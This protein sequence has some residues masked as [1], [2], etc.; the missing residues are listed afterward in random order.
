MKA[1]ILFLSLTA[2][3]NPQHKHLNVNEKYMNPQLNAEEWNKGFQEKDRD[4]VVFKKEIVNRLPI[5]EGQIIADVGAGTGQFESLLSKKVGPQG[6]VYAVDIAPAFIPFMKKRFAEEKL[7]NVEVV[8][9][10]L[11]S[12][13]LPDKSVDLIVVIDTYHHFDQHDKML[14]DFKRILKDKGH[15]V[16]V[17]FKRSKNARKWIMEH[18]S[19]TQEEYVNEITSFGFE[20]LRQEKI[21]FKESFQLTFRKI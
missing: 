9:S 21:P 16:V 20:F 2:F 6:K 10:K 11:D 13:T 12:S 8:Q 17:D 15:L 5:E 19:K 3:A 7:S 14:N 4:T 18:V 1:L